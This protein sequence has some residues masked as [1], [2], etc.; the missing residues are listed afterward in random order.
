MFTQYHQVMGGRTALKT[1]HQ[2]YILEHHALRWGELDHK[3]GEGFSGEID[4]GE[5]G[6]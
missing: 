4:F 2:A 5:I 1:V 6:N 3:L